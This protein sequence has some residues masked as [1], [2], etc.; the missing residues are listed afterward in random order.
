MVVSGCIIGTGVPFGIF[1]QSPVLEQ[2]F[3]RRQVTTLL[4]I[5]LQCFFYSIFSSQFTRQ[6]PNSKPK[7]SG[8]CLFHPIS[9][10]F[11]S[12][13]NS[14][15]RR[16]LCVF[17]VV[18]YSTARILHNLWGLGTEYRSRVV[19]TARQCW[20][21]GIDSLGFKKYR[22]GNFLQ[23]PANFFLF[24][25]LFFFYLIVFRYRLRTIN[26]LHCFSCAN[27]TEV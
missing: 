8:M 16:S 10:T 19:V 7:M 23:F 24:F 6:L 5:L 4:D 22:H 21:V 20:N 17:I 15:Y 13:G 27:H 2:H 25:F 9:F 12:P 26:T 1:S 18:L 14:A 3:Q 11:I